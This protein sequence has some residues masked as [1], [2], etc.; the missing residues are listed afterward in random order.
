MSTTPRKPSGKPP[1]AAPR[2]V[3]R[4]Q[5]GVMSNIESWIRIAV[6]YAEAGQ[7]RRGAPRRRG[8]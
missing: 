5:T 8:K 6:R 4:Y 2:P 7:K 3:W 1:A